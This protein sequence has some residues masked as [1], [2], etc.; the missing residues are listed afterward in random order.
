MTLDDKLQAIFARIDA[1][2]P[3]DPSIQTEW[4]ALT[5][6][7]CVDER[8]TLEYLENVADA[9]AANH[10]SAVFHDVAERLQS[11]AFIRCIESLEHKFPALTLNHMIEWAREAMHDDSSDD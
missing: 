5:D 4:D 11:T 3:E 8:A 2:H 6:A 10:V 9:R 7:L 1:M